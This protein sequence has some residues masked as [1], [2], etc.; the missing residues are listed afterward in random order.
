MTSEITK[1]P[2]YSCPIKNH[3][4]RYTMPTTPLHQWEHFKYDDGCSEFIERR[5][6][7]NL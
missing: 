7:E 6:D 1:C 3:C 4:L 2:G 5:V